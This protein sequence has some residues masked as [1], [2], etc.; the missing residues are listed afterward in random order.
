MSVHHQLVGAAVSFPLLPVIQDE[1]FLAKFSEEWGFSLATA[2]YK[3][4]IEAV[5]VKGPTL[6]LTVSVPPG[7][8]A[9][10]LSIVCPA[11]KLAVTVSAIW[12]EAENNKFVV[13]IPGLHFL[14]ESRSSAVRQVIAQVAQTSIHLRRSFL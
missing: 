13:E 6:S 12:Q 10:Q 2:Q 14:L 7:E 5:T 11:L 9:E 4:F 8:V 3:R 1:R